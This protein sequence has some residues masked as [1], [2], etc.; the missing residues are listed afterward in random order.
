MELSIENYRAYPLCRSYRHG[1]SHAQSTNRS[2][3]RSP[4]NPAKEVCR[5]DPHRRR[6]ICLQNLL[7][8]PETIF[9]DPLGT[10][11]GL[12][13]IQDV[14]IGKTMGQMFTK[15]ELILENPAIHVYGEAAWS[16][17][18]WTFH[19][20]L[21]GNGQE[22]TTR[23]R[24]TQIYHKENGEWHIVAVHYSSPAITAEPKGF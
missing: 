14:F 10:E 21:R 15:R 6:G 24:E 8:L 7:A 20:T 19:A 4:P 16:E 5:D 3:H 11:R 23:G 22:I 13:E 9:I 2:R 1:N 12:K 18:T 17:M